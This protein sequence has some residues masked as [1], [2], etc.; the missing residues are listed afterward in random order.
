H[1]YGCS[2]GSALWVGLRF[3]DFQSLK[4]HPDEHPI[5]PIEASHLVAAG[6]SP[7]RQR[8]SEFYGVAGFGFAAFMLVLIAI[9]VAN[10]PAGIAGEKER[11]TVVELTMLADRA[12]DK[13]DIDRAVMHLQTAASRLRAN[14]DE[15]VSR[16]EERIAELRKRE[17]Q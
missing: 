1:A 14:K 10:S 8:R 16:I 2:S 3:G 13:G 4:P 5:Q 9:G 15:R 17:I 11:I 12:A 7:D 6:A